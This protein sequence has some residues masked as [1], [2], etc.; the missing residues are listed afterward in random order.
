MTPAFLALSSS[1]TKSSKVFGSRAADLVHHRL[2]DPDPVDGVDV[3]GNGVPLAVG[4]GELLQRLRDD[5]GPAFLLGE[6]GDVAELA[7]FG[8]VEREIAEDLRGGRRVAGGH[9]RL[10]RR[11]RRLAAAAGDRNVLPGIAF[12]GESCLRTL[13][14]AASPPEVHQ[15]SIC[16]SLMSAAERRRRQ[17][18]TPRARQQKGTKFH[19]QS[20]HVTLPPDAVRLRLQRPRCDPR[21]SSGLA[22]VSRKL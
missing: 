12:L 20:F 4:G 10:Q 15:C 17:R 22:P 11:H 7:G 16:T 2:V 21:F 9:H 5:L 3:D 13:S 6:R 19:R 8:V 1:A 18:R 14:A